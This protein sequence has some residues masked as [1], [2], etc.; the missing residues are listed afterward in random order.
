MSAHLQES[1]KVIAPS[2]FPHATWNDAEVLGAMVWLWNKNSDYQKSALDCVLGVLLPI[3]KSRNFILVI[4]KNKPIGYMNWA[5]FDNAE[6]KSYLNQ[7]NDYLSFVQCFQADQTKK[8]WILTF[9]CPFG[10][11]NALLM[12]TICKKVL[13][14][15]LC[16][17]GYHKSKA[18]TVVRKI[19][20]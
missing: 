5:Y 3:I 19:Q 1:I 9:F 13:K 17:Y 14:N 15:Y 11:E 8:L 2:I 18:G 4:N 6:E 16:Y 10:L 20:C 12:K 7:T